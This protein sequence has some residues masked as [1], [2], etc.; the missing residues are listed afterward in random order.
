MAQVVVIQLV[1]ARALWRTF[2][3]PELAVDSTGIVPAA[4]CILPLIATSGPFEGRNTARAAGVD[5]LGPSTSV[6]EAR[7]RLL[8][9]GVGEETRGHPVCPCQ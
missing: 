5:Y 4:D 8:Q 6:A 1:A 7:W 3:E 2:L 9:E